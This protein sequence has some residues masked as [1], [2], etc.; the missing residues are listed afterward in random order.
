VK[1]DAVSGKEEQDK[2]GKAR[3]QKGK[4]TT[5]HTGWL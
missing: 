2:K 3:R 1:I 5:Q 4:V